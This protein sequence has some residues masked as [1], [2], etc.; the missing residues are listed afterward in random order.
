ML[1][2]RPAIIYLLLAGYPALLGPL[3]P[4]PSLFGTPF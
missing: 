3:S 2:A 4:S 1:C